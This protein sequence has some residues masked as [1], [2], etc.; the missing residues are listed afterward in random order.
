MLHYAIL[1]FKDV[2]SIL[3]LILRPQ[4]WAPIFPMC[5]SS[6]SPDGLCDCP[7][8]C[9]KPKG[10]LNV[11]ARQSDITGFA[12]NGAW[13]QQFGRKASW[14]RNPKENRIPDCEFAVDTISKAKLVLVPESSY[15]RTYLRN[16]QQTRRHIVYYSTPQ[17]SPVH[18][19]ASTDSKVS[20]LRRVKFVVHDLHMRRLAWGFVLLWMVS[21]SLHGLPAVCLK[22]RR[23]SDLLGVQPPDQ[24]CQH[25]EK[26]TASSTHSQDQ[27]RVRSSNSWCSLWTFSKLTTYI[28]IHA[29]FVRASFHSCTKP[30]WEEDVIFSNML[31]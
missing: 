20:W 22:Q 5:R 10:A 6:C 3:F 14:S 4:P 1:L 26:F 11:Q 8:G 21:A 18:T 9:D 31:C 13:I 23:L 24:Q 17:V 28:E 29:I 16:P 15:F 27:N 30:G 2:F 7:A 25:S 12:C 19:F